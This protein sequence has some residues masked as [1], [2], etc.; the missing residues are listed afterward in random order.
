MTLRRRIARGA[1]AASVALALTL[2]TG[3]CKQME[4]MSEKLGVGGTTAVGAGGGA[5]AGA[6]I[7]AAFGGKKGALI[8]AL[9]GGVAGGTAGYF[10]AKEVQKKKATEAQKREAEAK[11]ADRVR[12]TPPE[13]REQLRSAKPNSRVA[14]KLDDGTYQEVDPT[15]GRATETSYVVTP[16]EERRIREAQEKEGKLVKVDQYDVLFDP[17]TQGSAG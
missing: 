3:A 16:E 2:G 6:G 9:V 15:T 7:G 5:L 13:Q 8:G 11:Y 12:N 14:I 1:L 17:G 4:E 10:Y